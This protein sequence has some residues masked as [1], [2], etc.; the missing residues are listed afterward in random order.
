MKRRKLINYILRHEKLMYILKCVKNINNAEF[1][2][3]VNHFKDD[4]MFLEF[5]QKGELN[6]GHII[7]DL[8]LNVGN[9]TCN[10]ILLLLQYLNYAD[11][12]HM[13]PYVT[14]G[15]M[16]VFGEDEEVVNTKNPFEYFFKQYNNITKEEM[17]N[18]YRVAKFRWKDLSIYECFD[19]ID[20]KSM[21]T[22]GKIYKKY[23]CLNQDT[24]YYID[25]SIDRIGIGKETIGVH[26]REGS[27]K[28]GW[29][30]HMIPPKEDDYYK[31]IDEL[32]EKK[33]FKKV[34][35][36]TD[37]S[38]VVDKFRKKYNNRLLF[39]SDLCRT[40]NDYMDP[41]RVNNEKR[42][43]HKYKCALEVIRDYYSLA[44]CGAFIG[45]L[46]S[47]ST[48]V[49]VLKMAKNETFIYETILDK[50]INREGKD[51]AVANKMSNDELARWVKNKKNGE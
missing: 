2:Y 8:Y 24:Q 19:V 38:R 34:F 23:L 5:E 17:N 46:S 42:P 12:L 35:L 11:S 51:V 32:L 49:R 37:D 47:V 27:M 6:R 45:N 7:Y 48:C 14:F 41:V 43:R 22:F 28:A 40:D 39:Y 15:D 4:V 9:G 18:S 44:S 13:W 33:V 20:E 21:V 10:L 1:I 16:C 50:G 31:K 3:K 25:S 26:V 36:A 30:N 29:K